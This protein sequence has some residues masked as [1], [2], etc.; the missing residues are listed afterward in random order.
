[1]NVHERVEY[2]EEE[3][4]QLREA[5]TGKR[6]GFPFEWNLTRGE[7]MVLNALYTSPNRRRTHEALL[8]AS[9]LGE[10]ASLKMIQVRICKLRQ[11]LSPLGIAITTNRCEGYELSARSIEII[12]EALA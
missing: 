3:N 2:L 5:V 12:R 7:E 11:K 8:I 9:R 6:V 10:D 4:R 1:M